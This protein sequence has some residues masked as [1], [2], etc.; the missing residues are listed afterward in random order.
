MAVFADVQYTVWG[1]PITMWTRK[2]VEVRRKSTVDQGEKGGRV[3]KM[4]I[5]VHSRGVG[6]EIWKICSM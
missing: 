2:G 3:C 6:V 5:F 4:S 1:H